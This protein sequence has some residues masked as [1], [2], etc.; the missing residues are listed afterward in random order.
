M[1]VNQIIKQDNG[2]GTTTVTVVTDNGN[3]ATNTYDH[4]WSQ[5][6]IDDTINDTVQ[7]ALNKD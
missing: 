7:E 5:S 3:S 4:D 2:D 1:A 6:H